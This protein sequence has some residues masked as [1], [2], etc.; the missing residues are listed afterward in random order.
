M[1]K[2]VTTFRDEKLRGQMLYDLNPVDKFFGVSNTLFQEI[3]ILQYQPETHVYLQL[4]RF[5]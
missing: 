4:V 2:W 1:V 5:F 3:K